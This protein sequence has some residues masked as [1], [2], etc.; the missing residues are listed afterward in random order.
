MCHICII[1]LWHHWFRLWLVA[2][3]VPSPLHEPM[4]FIA[5]CTLIGTKFNEIR[6]KLQWFP[7]NKMHQEI[8]SA[9][10][11][12]FCL[13]VKA[14]NTVTYRYLRSA[15]LLLMVFP[16][17]LCKRAT[18]PLC[19]AAVALRPASRQHRVVIATSRFYYPQ[20]GHRSSRYTKWHK[21]P[22]C[23]ININTIDINTT[24]SI[25]QFL[26]DISI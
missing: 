18:Q 20:P 16:R 19:T 17:H 23:I 25:H 22:I 13:G 21:N 14:L 5:K 9:K 8:P 4:Y 26:L 3:S 10:W 7:L 24:P 12:P 15:S 2:C 1:K 11:W 6:V